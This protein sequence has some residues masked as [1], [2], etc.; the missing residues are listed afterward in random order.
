MRTTLSMLLGGLLFSATS[1][2]AITVPMTSLTGDIKKNVGTVTIEQRGD[3]VLFTPD[4][5]GLTPGAHGFHVHMNPSC[6][7]AGNDAGGH[8]DPK[9][10]KKHLGPY[11]DGHRGDLPVLSVNKD[12]TATAPVYA[13]HLTV[14][15]IKGRSLMIHAGGD[16]FADQPQ[17]LGGGGQRVACG[18]IQ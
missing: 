16:N 4:L 14:D 5:K 3:G 15:E 10:A 1:F 7:N 6:G 11:A 17:P 8:Y 2:A 13:P 9:N 12:G 18:V